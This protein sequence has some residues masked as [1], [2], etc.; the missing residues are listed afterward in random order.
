VVL[1]V[2]HPAA[3]VVPVVV[4]AVAHLAAVVVLVVVLAVA[5]VVVV[6]VVVPAVALVV[7]AAELPRPA[8]TTRPASLS[9]FSSPPAT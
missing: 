8:Y 6:P 3:V 4:L 1:A 9:S 2:A 5:L 7:V